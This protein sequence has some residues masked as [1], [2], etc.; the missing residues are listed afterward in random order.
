MIIVCI[1]IDY[2]PL[3][4]PGCCLHEKQHVNNIAFKQINMLLHDLSV[5]V[6]SFISVSY[7]V[8]EIRLSILKNNK[9]NDKKKTDLFDNQLYRLKR[10]TRLF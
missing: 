4:W 7:L 3:Y 9:D 10:Y 1:G 6:Q 2:S 8:F 5:I